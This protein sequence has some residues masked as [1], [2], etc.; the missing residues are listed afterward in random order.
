MTKAEKE[1]RLKNETSSAT[2]SDR[3][4]FQ[5]TIYN[6]TGRETDLNT[7]IKHLRADPK[8][9]EATAER[10][11]PKTQLKEKIRSRPEKKSSSANDS[12]TETEKTATGLAVNLNS[13]QFQIW[14]IFDRYFEDLAT[15]KATGV[16]RPIPPRIF[17]HGGPSAGKTYLINAIGLLQK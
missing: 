3:I 15:A 10:P 17:V 6:T 13:E 2:E 12:G 16:E 14:E 5:S 4:S 11:I 1:Q 8:K 9:E 7:L